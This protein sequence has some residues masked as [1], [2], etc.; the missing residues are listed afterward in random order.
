[1][2]QILIR[3]TFV[4]LCS[5]LFASCGNAQTFHAIIFAATADDKIG[6]SVEQDYYRMK[7]EFSAISTAI[8]MKLAQMLITLNSR[9]WQYAT[10][11][12][13]IMILCRYKK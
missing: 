4:L 2:K 5:V 12:A 7:A 6:P 10:M 11:D 3:L 1:M 9:N 13:E 8:G